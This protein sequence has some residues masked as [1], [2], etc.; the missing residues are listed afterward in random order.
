MLL[1]QR[2]L[3]IRFHRANL[4]R[5]LT[6]W[7]VHQIR[8]NTSSSV[9]GIPDELLFLSIPE[10]RGSYLLLSG[11]SYKN[12]LT[13][14]DDYS[15]KCK[16][17]DLLLCWQYASEKPPPTNTTRKTFRCQILQKMH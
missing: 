1:I 17:S 9:D 4:D 11:S 2:L 7:N 10:I 5:M 12:I 3:E 14:H 6:A 13:G 8:H 16:D 15:R